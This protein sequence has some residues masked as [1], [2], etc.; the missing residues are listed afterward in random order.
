VSGISGES[1]T[2]QH[3][4]SLRRSSQRLPSA[5]HPECGAITFLASVHR[6]GVQSLLPGIANHPEVD[7]RNSPDQRKGKET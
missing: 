3:A 6:I 1:L 4:V 2:E 7:H 5:L